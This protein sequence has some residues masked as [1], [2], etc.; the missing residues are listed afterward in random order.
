MPEPEGSP[1]ILVMPADLDSLELSIADPSINIATPQVKGYRC[2]EMIMN[3]VM[4]FSERKSR[5][6]SQVISV[7]EIANCPGS[8][9]WAV[10]SFCCHVDKRCRQAGQ[11]IERSWREFRCEILAPRIDQMD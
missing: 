7:E 4:D 9:K 11:V 10:D 6:V 5:D 8:F 3:Y 1:A 2:G